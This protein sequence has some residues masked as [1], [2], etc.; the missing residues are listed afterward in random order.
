MSTTTTPFLVRCWYNAQDKVLQV[1]VT[2]I[3]TEEHVPLASSS[4]L[5]RVTNVSRETGEQ[6]YLHMHHIATNRDA[7]VQG[8]PGLLQFVK[9]CL[10]PHAPN[11]DTATDTD[12]D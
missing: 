2:R 10:L 4:F 8:G 1:Q 7:Y 11:P 9:D 5:I 3:D 12:D 6:T